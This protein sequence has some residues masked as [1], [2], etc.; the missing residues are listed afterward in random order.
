MDK[1]FGKQQTKRTQSRTTS[2]KY[3]REAYTIAFSTNTWF[4]FW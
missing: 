3:V 1:K 4:R 2:D